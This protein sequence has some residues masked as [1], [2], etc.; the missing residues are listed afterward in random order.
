MKR[1]SLIPRVLAGQ[2]TL[3]FAFATATFGQGNV[4]VASTPNDN[5][6][7]MEAFNVTDMKAFS[8]QAIPD[9]TPVAFTEYGKEKIVEELGSRDL[10]LL[11][12][13]S[14]SVYATNDSGGAGDARINVRGF[15]QRNIS[16]LIN[17]V[18]TNDME[19]G[20]LYWSNWDGLGDVSAAIQMQRGL[21]AVTLPSPSI[22]G[23]MNIIT[24]PASARRG[25]S[26]KVEA[27]YDDFYK[28][29]GVVNTGL[30]QDKFAVTVGG[31]VKKGTESNSVRGTWTEGAAYYVGA[32]YKVNPR[33]RLE[34]FVIGAPQR[35]GQRRF[36]SN[37]AAYDAGYARN[38]GYTDADIAG[39]ATRGP[40]N[41][42]RDF[43]PNWAP[44]DP[45][46]T[47]QQYWNRGLHARYKDNFLNQ[48]ENYFH[49]P[50]MNLNW[51]STLSDQLKLSSVVYFSGGFGGG[52]STLNN[53]TGWAYI[54][55]SDPTYGSAT[56]WNAVIAANAG[57][58]GVSGASKTA[59]RSL[60]ILTNSVNVQSE[61][62]AVS[63]LT[64]ALS[65]SVTLTAG[66][67]W[68]TYE[69]DHFNEVR[70][71]LGGSYY[72]A[73]S[74]QD[75]DFWADGLNT[76]LHL[77]DKV[78]YYYHSTVD[79]LGGFLQGQYEKGPVTAFAAYGASGTD[80][81][82]IDQFHK[83]S[84]GTPVTLKS[85]TF[86]GQQVKGG[87]RYAFTKQFSLYSNA[88]WVERA[89]VFT[90]A[91]DTY[92]SKLVSDAPNEN[93]RSAE[94]GARWSTADRK[95]NL[96]AGYYFTQWR[97]RSSTSSSNTSV[98][99]RRGINADYSGLELEATYQPARW[100]RLDGAGSIANA[101]YTSDAT[102]QTISDSTHEIISA[103]SLYIR[104]L[105]VGD[106]PQTQFSGG[107]TVY[108]VKG[109]SVTV[110]GRWYDRYWADYDPT[111]RT[112]SSDRG[113]SWQLPNYSVW[114]VHVNYRLPLK[115]DRYVVTTFLHV[116]NLFDKEYI[117]DATDNSSYE[118][119]PGAPSH[120][121]QRAEVFFGAPR[122]AN[123]G[124]RLQF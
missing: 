59:G 80:Y 33:N 73:T 45:S 67:D 93:F 96:S 83:N 98:S 21:S 97:D 102:V 116:F 29:T 85:S 94:A 18:P 14:P 74:S 122:G 41:A 107:V 124:V 28:A 87:I 32:L 62:G 109:L 52:S 4:S 88:G 48:Y 104:D 36:A 95:F 66:A 84:A 19:N 49:K 2:F 58:R 103:G 5:I 108:P 53:G 47:G 100:I 11:M 77:G 89:P 91:I 35:H 56:D 118:G 75:S 54:P 123:V 106:A 8:D 15:D 10:P 37:I 16:I 63:K 26:I 20:W 114:D 51:Y 13:S 117:S 43:N 31:V 60:A 113:Q 101:H 120:S 76:Q 78:S 1:S 92:N 90:T 71:L 17:G 6:V 99:Y 64:Y 30:L 55:N 3:S 112:N 105:K 40:V 69:A 46:Y 61:I 7:K 111:S 65:P 44:V 121:A 22:G 70:D 110:Q 79:W 82:Y 12:N 115:S 25:I 72:L 119:V 50:Q 23:T 81:G 38:L 39:A 9:K 86:T 57:S 68:R 34:F 42:G 24:D 27:G